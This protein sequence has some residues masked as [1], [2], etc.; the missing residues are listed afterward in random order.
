MNGNFEAIETLWNWVKETE[1][2]P[3]DLLLAQIEKEFILQIA[4]HE[5]HVVIL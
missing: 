3:C 2:N 4:A 1:L 5:K